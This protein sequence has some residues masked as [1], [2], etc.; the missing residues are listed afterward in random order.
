[1]RGRPDND[2]ELMQYA[3]D[4]LWG[5]RT[6]KLAEGAKKISAKLGEQYHNI[7]EEL[8]EVAPLLKKADAVFVKKTKPLTD[9][10]E[11]PIGSLIN[12][13]AAP[14]EYL[15]ALVQSSPEAAAQM[16]SIFQSS[17]EVRA[18]SVPGFV[19]LSSRTF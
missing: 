19:E 2:L 11:T 4:A 14:D 9:L 12:T 5:E 17:Q 1:M 7:G 13:D 15:K 16:R 6:S 8:K 18:L 10:Y 3:R